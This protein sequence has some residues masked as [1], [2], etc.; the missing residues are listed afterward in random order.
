MGAKSP[1]C[2]VHEN[3]VNIVSVGFVFVNQLFTIKLRFQTV[4]ARFLLNGTVLAGL[5]FVVPLAHGGSIGF[6]ISFTG[7]NIAITNTGSEPAYQVSQWTLDADSHWQRV[8]VVSGNVSYL[9]PGQSLKGRRLT[10]AAPT[11]LG[12]AD[13]LLVLLHDQAGGR[14]AQLAWRH[15]PMTQQQPLP[16]RRQGEQLSVAADAARVQKITT[17]YA[18]SVPY[19]GIGRLG[20]HLSVT[21]VPP[22]PLHHDWVSDAPLVIATG[23]AQGGAWLVHENANAEL[24]LQIVPDGV[25]R[26]QEQVSVWLSWVRHY[27][28]Q[29]AAWL[30]GLGGLVLAVGWLWAVR[31][32]WVVDCRS[33]PQ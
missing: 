11:G 12:R 10:S 21:D 17:S 25:V 14:I 9:A 20:Q 19:D 28:L 27:L 1:H 5:V 30:A 26:G 2:S 22:N 6:S 31:R 15:P 18:L 32:P 13:P 8:Q 33:G 7:D 24:S 4:L 3:Y 16:T 29:V 23:T